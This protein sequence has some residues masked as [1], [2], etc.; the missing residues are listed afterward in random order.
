MEGS[1]G[2]LTK[3]GEDEL[4]DKKSYTWHLPNPMG[5]TGVFCVQISRAGLWGRKGSHVVHYC[6]LRA[7]VSDFCKLPKDSR[8]CACKLQPSWL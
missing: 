8:M 4:T 5:T 3:P 2:P 6:R 1:K 7:S